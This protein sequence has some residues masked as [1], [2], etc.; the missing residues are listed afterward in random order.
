MYWAK[1]TVIYPLC[2]GN[3]YVVAPCGNVN[4]HSP[5]LDEF[6][7]EFPGLCLVQVCFFSYYFFKKGRCFVIEAICGLPNA[8]SLESLNAPLHLFFFW[9]GS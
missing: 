1:A 9:G 6:A 8:I 2:E 7:K 3:V 4:I 5:L